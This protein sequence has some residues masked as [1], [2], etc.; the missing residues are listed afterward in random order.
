MDSRRLRAPR[1]KDKEKKDKEK[2]E[3]K[4]KKKAE[5]A[6]KAINSSL[7]TGATQAKKPAASQLPMPKPKVRL[8]RTVALNHEVMIMTFNR[9]SFSGFEPACKWRKAWAGFLSKAGN[10]GPT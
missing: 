1:K 4:E 5:K 6:K 7:I 2:K 3:K 10:L 9:I 8:S